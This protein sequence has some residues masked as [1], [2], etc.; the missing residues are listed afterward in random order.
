MAVH[1]HHISSVV[2]V[3]TNCL[4]DRYQR[5]AILGLKHYTQLLVVIPFIVLQELDG[6]KSGDG[7]V[8][9]EA[10]RA[11]QFLSD[12]VS[13]DRI[14]IRGQCY[15]EVP[16]NTSK[17]F[18][19]NDD[20]ILKCCLYFKELVEEDD[21]NSPYDV[22]L[23]T[24][25]RV[26]QVK[27]KSH[28]TSSLDCITLRDRLLDSFQ[29]TVR[30]CTGVHFRDGKFLPALSTRTPKSPSK[31]PRSPSKLTRSPSKASKKSS[32]KPIP[33]SSSRGG[34]VRTTAFTS[35]T[36]HMRGRAFANPR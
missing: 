18:S 28:H 23:L 26:L 8:S 31:Y 35:P 17:L 13:Q 7:A 5:E 21:G 10:R 12:E 29:E 25:D 24:K 15:D 32:S 11:V 36:K 16:F 4:L 27:A 14:W 19:N 2:V 22:L 9:L 1:H 3:D 20:Q 34:L 30:L 6:L 33:S